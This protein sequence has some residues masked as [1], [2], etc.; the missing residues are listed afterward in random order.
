MS[1]EPDDGGDGRPKIL[2]KATGWIGGLTAL[3]V[4]LAGLRAA[5]ND[6]KP[7]AAAQGTDV[8]SQ[9]TGTGNASTNSAETNAS[10][11]TTTDAAPGPKLATSYKGDGVTMDWIDRQW[12]VTDSDGTY[13]YDQQGDRSDGMTYART[14]TENMPCDGRTM[15]AM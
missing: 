11:T 5:Y 12:I 14:S 15:A 7:P 6:L 2:N 8:Q 9:D 10:D 1:G 13:K 4:A 3:V